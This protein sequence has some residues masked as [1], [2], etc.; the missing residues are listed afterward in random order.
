[1]E[2]ILYIIGGII[3]ISF[4]WG[5]G[6]IPEFLTLIGFNLFVGLVSGIIAWIF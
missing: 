5:I 1:M 2:W 3:L 4:L 6:L